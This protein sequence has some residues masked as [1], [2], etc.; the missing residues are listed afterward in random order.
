MRRT[1][2]LIL[3]ALGVLC[4]VVAGVCGLIVLAEQDR[5]D[6][7]TIAS[8][9]AVSLLFAGLLIL[10][11]ASIVLRVSP[12]YFAPV[13]EGERVHGFIADQAEKRMRGK[14][15]YEVHYTSP[16]PKVQPALVVRVAAK[17]ATT[18]QFTEENW[19]DRLCKRMGIA[20][21]VQT[22]D[23]EFDDAIY[24]RCPSDGFARQYL[25]NAGRRRAILALRKAGFAWV[26]LTGSAVEAHWPQFDPRTAGVP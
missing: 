25:E 1:I 14:R 2:G 7:F 16:R 9:L 20:Q 11:L 19:F 5:G 17:S 24:V 12:P 18:V 13:Q 4:L 10:F 26:Q 15:A 8:T 22:G 6:V 21:E 23:C 3:L